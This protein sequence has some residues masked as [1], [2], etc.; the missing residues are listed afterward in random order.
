MIYSR[1][2]TIG[3]WV[4]GG[5]LSAGCDERSPTR[6]QSGCV[7]SA[8]ADALFQLSP[9]EL[10]TLNRQG[11]EGNLAAQRK[12]YFYYSVHV[13][14][15]KLAYWEDRLVERDGDGGALRLRAEKA[16]REARELKDA[17][18]EKVVRLRQAQSFDERSKKADPPRDFNAMVNGKWL[19]ID[20][21]AG[22][23]EFTRKIHAELERVA[24]KQA[25]R[26]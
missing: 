1:N 21:V 6:T 24:V 10:E 7:S 19:R 26:G 12:L 9:A 11:M 14:P 25:K 3:L 17:D 15:K 16:L 5:L 2:I 18:P 22:A 23:D 13:D 20:F 8:C 4:F